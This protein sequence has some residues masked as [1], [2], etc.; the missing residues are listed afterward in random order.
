MLRG[1]KGIVFYSQLAALWC[2]QDYVKESKQKAYQRTIGT[3]IGALYGLVVLV[4][5]A[6]ISVDGLTE[7][8]LKSV[9]IY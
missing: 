9:V 5:F 7:D 4:I 2:M 6:G 8:I 1:G 3:V